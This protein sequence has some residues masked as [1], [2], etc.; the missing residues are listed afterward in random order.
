M[1]MTLLSTGNISC[2][3]NNV[4]AKAEW[5]GISI[6]SKIIQ[7]PKAKQKLL[8]LWALLWTMFS[9]SGLYQPKFNKRNIR[10]C[11]M[12]DISAKTSVRL[13]CACGCVSLL[14]NS[15]K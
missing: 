7:Q 3:N 6:S 13:L 10:V 5:N 12:S 11:V 9:K 1:K 14:I 4:F 8:I 15:L 2:D